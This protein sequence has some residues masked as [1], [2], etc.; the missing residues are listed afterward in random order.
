MPP[1]QISKW[2][3]RHSFQHCLKHGEI[4]TI[5]ADCVG[6]VRSTEQRRKRQAPASCTYDVYVLDSSSTGPTTTQTVNVSVTHTCSGI[7]SS[8]RA[9]LLAECFKANSKN[10]NGIESIENVVVLLTS[11]TTA[12]AISPTAL[13]TASPTNGFKIATIVIGVI[14]GVSLFGFVGFLKVR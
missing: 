9:D 4:C 6:Y 5:G 7:Y 13:A 11:P 12:P 1:P 14:L 3:Y 8:I 2:Y 10:F